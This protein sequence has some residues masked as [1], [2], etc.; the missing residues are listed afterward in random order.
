MTSIAI[1][2]SMWLSSFDCARSVIYRL[3][4]GVTWAYQRPR[5]RE[6]RWTAR[7]L[8]ESIA[9]SPRICNKTFDHASESKRGGRPDGRMNYHAP[10][11]ETRVKRA[12][13]FA[14]KRDV[15]L[16]SIHR[17]AIGN[18]SVERQ[19]Y[20]ARCKH[21]NYLTFIL[22]LARWPGSNSSSRLDIVEYS[23]CCSNTNSESG[24]TWKNRSLR[25]VS[26]RGDRIESHWK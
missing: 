4:C 8:R 26:F 19:K 6:R 24:F 9:P 22:S 21:R 25:N 23:P 10:S 12:I 2:S 1:I 3:Y 15:Y 18:G 13:L 7:G 17:G 11:R 5:C 14:S 20:T 16:W